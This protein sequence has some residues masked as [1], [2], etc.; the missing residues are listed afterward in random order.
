MDLRPFWSLAD[1]LRENSLL[2][3]KFV[4]Y[5]LGKLIEW[6]AAISSSGK[7]SVLRKLSLRNWTFC[8]PICTV[9]P[10]FHLAGEG[11]EFREGIMMYQVVESLKVISWLLLLVT[12]STWCI[13]ESI[14][15]FFILFFNRFLNLVFLLCIGKKSLRHH[16]VKV[17]RLSRFIDSLS[18]KKLLWSLNEM[19][20]YGIRIL[21]Y[22]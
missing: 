17:I 10:P 20:E 14:H 8:W 13:L 15:Q 11:V 18:D 9:G 3:K 12:H 2:G 5:L 19:M 7:I 22:L 1:F 4:I 16:N 6:C 21:C